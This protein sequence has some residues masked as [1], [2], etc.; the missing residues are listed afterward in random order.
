MPMSLAFD[1]G[2][3][4]PGIHPRKIKKYI[5]KKLYTK[6]FIVA[7]FMILQNW[8]TRSPSTGKWINKLKYIN[9]MQ[10]YLAMKR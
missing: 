1:V 7:T 8:K 9:K 3:S 6:K 5:D 10:Y 4:H 2:I